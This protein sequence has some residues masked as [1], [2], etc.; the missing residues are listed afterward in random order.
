MNL[1]NTFGAQ[2]SILL[3]PF[4]LIGFWQVRNDIRA[5]FATTGWLLLFVAMT[6]GFPLIGARGG[7][8]H[9]G[10][11]F[12]S[13]WWSLA[14]LGL[15][16][17][18]AI[19]RKRKTFTAKHSG[20]VFQGMLVV[21]CAL[22]S[23]VIIQL[24]ILQPGWHPESEMYEQVEQILIEQGAI[25]DEIAIVRNPALYYIVS[26]RSTIVMPP[27]GPDTIL[28]LASKYDATY[29]ILEPEGVLEEYKQLYEQPDI[30]SVLE[31]I[32]EV[33]GAKIYAIHIAE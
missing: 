28:A 13:Y 2:G 8:F 27:G 18:S 21:I 17:F 5:K 19:L 23:G 12:Q 6:L 30:R 11:A 22:L 33:E 20:T 10:A 15:Q 3:F 24:R 9:A 25:S 16:H 14:P 26:G 31:F 32:G 1:L 29:F 7:F 4:I